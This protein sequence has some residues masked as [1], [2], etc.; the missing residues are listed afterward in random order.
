MTL[1]ASGSISARDI[2]IELGLSGTTTFAMGSSASRTLAGV[3]SGPIAMGHFYGKSNVITGTLTYTGRTIGTKGYNGAWGTNPIDGSGGWPYC[4]WGVGQGANSSGT[5][6]YPYI[7]PSGT[8][9][10]FWYTYGCDNS[11]S[12]GVAT[13]TDKSA[14]PTTLTY[15]DLGTSGGF[16]GTNS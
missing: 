3:S 15:T 14:D 9:Q 16:P 11:G 10:K 8:G 4:A 1:Q 2:N 6:Y 12:V 5:T 13:T 7:T